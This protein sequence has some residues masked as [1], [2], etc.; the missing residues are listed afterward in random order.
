M[1]KSG[2]PI[3]M[4]GVD[5][6]ECGRAEGLMLEVKKGLSPYGV[7]VLPMSIAFPSFDFWKLM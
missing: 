3:K 7:E 2:D 4:K 1:S 6:E 5:H